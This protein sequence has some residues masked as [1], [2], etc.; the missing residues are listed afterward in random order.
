M[1]H[2]KNLFFIESVGK[3]IQMN[4]PER[5]LYIT[6]IILRMIANKS[7]RIFKRKSMGSRNQSQ[8]IF[9]KS[10]DQIPLDLIDPISISSTIVF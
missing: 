3:L 7:E 1:S 10:F 9:H 4:L 8:T 5:N 6:L 2:Q